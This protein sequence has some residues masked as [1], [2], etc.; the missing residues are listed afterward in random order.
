MG[1]PKGNKF[2]EVWNEETT[3]NKLA[4]ITNYIKEN[5]KEFHL[6]GILVQCELYPDWWSDMANKFSNNLK[7]YR[8]IKSIETLLEQRII[9]ATIS[10]EAKSAA[11]AIF[12]LKN[13]HGYKDKTE[14][15]VNLNANLKNLDIEF[16]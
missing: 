10:G 4:E 9:N 6:G 12:Y 2:A 16:E 5:K 7:V 15:D 3:L 13:K 8:T 11:M 14:Q 1:A